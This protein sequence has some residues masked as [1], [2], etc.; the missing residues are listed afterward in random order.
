MTVLGGRAISP[1][2]PSTPH[3]EINTPNPEPQPRNGPGHPVPSDRNGSG[4]RERTASNYFRVRNFYP[5]K[6][7][8]EL[9]TNR[10]PGIFLV[11]KTSNSSTSNYFLALA[12]GLRGGR[13]HEDL[14][15]LLMQAT[16]AF[17]YSHGTYKT[18]MGHVRQSWHI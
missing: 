17:F 16:P 15:S 9:L 14:K 4:Q 6:F 18:V 13:F 3:A 1:I 8:S 12:Q 2:N 11:S 10:L 7:V 5:T